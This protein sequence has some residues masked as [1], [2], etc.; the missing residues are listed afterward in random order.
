MLL[1]TEISGVYLVRFDGF[2]DSRG[3]FRRLLDSQQL[4]QWGVNLVTVHVNISTISKAGTIKGFHFQKA[5]LGETKLITC[6]SGRV[7]DVALDVRLESST[8][9]KHVA[10]ELVDS[11]PWSVLIPEGVAHAVQSLSAGSCMLYMHSAPYSRQHEMGINPLDPALNIQWPL[12]PLGLSE[13]DRNLPSLD[14]VTSSV[15]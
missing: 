9:G 13:R 15:T 12:E 11:Q 2:E 4:A 7:L 14:S 8:F 3:T 1:P 6:T 10:Y 5:P